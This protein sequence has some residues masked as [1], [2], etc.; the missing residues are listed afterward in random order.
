MKNKCYEC[1][2][3]SKNFREIFESFALIFR[4]LTNVSSKIDEFE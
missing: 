1:D 4:K 3:Y 2:N